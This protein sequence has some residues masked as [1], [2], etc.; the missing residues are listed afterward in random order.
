[1]GNTMLLDMLSAR[2]TAEQNTAAL[3]MIERIRNGSASADQ[4][5]PQ[6]LMASL[7]GSN[8]MLAVFLQ[9]LQQQR[10]SRVIEGGTVTEVD[11]FEEAAPEDERPEEFAAEAEPLRYRG[12]PA[13]VDDNRELRARLVAL[14]DEVRSLRDR[15]ELLA[16]ALGAC[17][18]CWGED[19][20]CRAC[21]GRGSPGY[22]KPDE[23]LFNE[24]VFPA[25]QMLR[26]WRANKHPAAPPKHL[27]EPRATPASSPHF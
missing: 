10:Q 8:P 15:E 11:E 1:M 27:T 13:L 5:D 17:C 24:L 22:A 26:A 3:E 4:P 23:E 20:Q 6:Q 12:Q 25:M 9:H 16:D 2:A 14:T 21:R 7:G 18:M 19:P